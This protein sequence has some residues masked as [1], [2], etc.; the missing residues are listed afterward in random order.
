MTK[1]PRCLLFAVLLGFLLPVTGCSGEDS[2]SPDAGAR[3]TAVTSHEAAASDQAGQLVDL[4]SLTTFKIA[5]VQYGK[6]TYTTAAPGCKDDVCA[7]SSLAR[8]ASKA[9]ARLVVFPEYSL[10]QA[11]PWDPPAAMGDMPATDAKYQ[12][13][14]VV[15][16]FAALAVETKMFVVF[17]LKTQE[18]VG[19]VTRKYNTDVAVNPSGKVVAVHHKF[20][21]YSAF[22]KSTFT[23]GASQKSSFFQTPAG[24]TGVLICADIHCLITGLTT[25][26]KCTAVGVDRVKQFV[27]E[28]PDVVLVSNYWFT[29]ADTPTWGSMVVGGTVAKQMKAYVATSNTTKGSG[30]GGAIYDPQGTILAK[31]ISTSASVVYAE[32]PVAK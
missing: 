21:L 29:A 11:N 18:T 22:E 15:R 3:D 25:S 19:G 23:A 10:Y 5:A 31:K 24:K 27:A 20:E 12:S 32:I 2:A 9:G 16:P 8:E 7:L 14:T 17:N 30:Y 6:G 26:D 13:T 1:F 4:G 28:K